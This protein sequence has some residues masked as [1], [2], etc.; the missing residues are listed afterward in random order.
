M[1]GYIITGAAALL[2]FGVAK[3]AQADRFYNRLNVETLGGRIHKITF[4]KITV[5][6]K[7]KLKNPTNTSLTIQYPYVEL[8]Y[9]GE[10]I[11]S[12]EVKN[13]TIQIPRYGEPEKEL[14]IDIYLLKLSVIAADMFRKLSTQQGTVAVQGKTYTSIVTGANSR[15]ELPAYEFTITL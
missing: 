6:V 2:A 14:L 7:S 9:K 15:V 3:A 10:M 12:S 8:Y 4:S 11:G 1:I 5:A 13:E